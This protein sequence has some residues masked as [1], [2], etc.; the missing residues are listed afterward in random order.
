MQP[1]SNVK[2]SHKKNDSDSVSCLE[3]KL[4][5]AFEDL[6]AANGE[7][8]ALNSLNA[9]LK[10][11]CNSWREKINELKDKNVVSQ[12]DM[13]HAKAEEK[14]SKNMSSQTNDCTRILKIISKLWNEISCHHRLIDDKNSKI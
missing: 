12:P 3:N 5:L 8:D 13:S 2:I 1:Y 7:I 10:T 14:K 6:K 4:S 11:E 9:T